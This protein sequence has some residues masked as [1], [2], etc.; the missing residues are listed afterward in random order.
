MTRVDQNI[1]QQLKH[2]HIKITSV[3]QK[4]VFVRKYPLFI[5]FELRGVEPIA[6][7]FPIYFILL[8]GKHT[9]NMLHFRYLYTMQ[10]LVH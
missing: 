8:E 7:M 5:I 6:Q 1:K 3:Q 4:V 2:F 9:C 10:Y